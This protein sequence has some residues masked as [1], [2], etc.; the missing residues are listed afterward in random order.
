MDC[1]M[2][3]PEFAFAR[4]G[5][6]EL[7]QLLALERECFGH[8]WTERQ[9]LLGLANK[10]FQVFGLKRGEELAAYCSFHQAAG[11]MEILNIAVAPALRR[12]GLARRLFGLVLQICR[13]L[14]IEQGYLEVRRSNAAAIAL[15]ESFGFAAVGVRKGYYPDN[16]E[17]AVLMRLDLADARPQPSQPKETSHDPL[18]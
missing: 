3:A 10:A 12:R 17:D 5:P 18:A 9:F 13:N 15:Y 4:L 1:A 7:P 2:D 11:E 6:A 16:G 14:G 8:P